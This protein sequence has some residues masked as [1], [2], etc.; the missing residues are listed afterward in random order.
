MVGYVLRDM[1]YE[2]P[3][4]ELLKNSLHDLHK[5]KF[6]VKVIDDMNAYE[7]K[8]SKNEDIYRIEQRTK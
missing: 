1:D 6:D 7:I 4:I 3:E 5:I 8:G 2:C